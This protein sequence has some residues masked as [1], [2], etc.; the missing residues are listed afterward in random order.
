MLHSAILP[1]PDKLWNE[2]RPDLTE[3]QLRTL[4]EPARISGIKN[5]YL[6]LLTQIARA[7]AAQGNISAAH[8]T[9]NYVE[10]ELQN[11]LDLACIYYLIERARV[12][13]LDAHT[14]RAES[15]LT[16]ALN[17]ATSAQHGRLADTAKQMLDNIGRR[18][19]S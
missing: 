8:E 10:R 4:I 13:M 16:R 1:N 14:E 6:Q 17:C 11:G 19:A 9:L 18:R 3:N 5:Y 2:R 7:Q 12:E 15:L